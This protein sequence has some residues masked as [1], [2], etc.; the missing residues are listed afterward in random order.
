MARKCLLCAVMITLIFTSC[1]KPTPRFENHGFYY[2][3]TV[4]KVTAEDK[5]I[6]DRLKINKLYVRLFDVVYDQEKKQ[7]RPEQPV[8]FDNP[9]IEGIEIIPVV[10]IMQDVFDKSSKKQLESLPGNIFKFSNTLLQKNQVNFNEFQLDYDWVPGTKERYF[11]FIRDFTEMLRGKNNKYRISVTLRLHELKYSK[12]T[13]IPPVDSVNLMAYN[14]L[15]PRKF[16][17]QNTVFNMNELKKYINYSRN[18]PLSINPILPYFQTI[19]VY[20]NGNLIKILSD[21]NEKKLKDKN[22]FD[23]IGSGI[24]LAKHN[25][26]TGG[27]EIMTNYV[28]KIEKTSFKD[29]KKG[30]KLMNKYLKMGSTISIFEF[31]TKKIA[32]EE[33]EEDINNFISILNFS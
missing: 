27:F 2:W 23:S 12:E 4:F 13:G 9:H 25:F 19:F 32:G 22:L 17:E 18:Y 1:S 20:K 31:D 8:V 21:I 11:R 30:I 26:R 15:D 16:S 7:P 33:N 14:I 5:K 3:K 6:L 24:Y 28:V 10:F 29:I